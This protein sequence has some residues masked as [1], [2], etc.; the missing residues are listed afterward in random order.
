MPDPQL[1]LVAS[2]HAVKKG[3]HR[4]ELKLEDDNGFEEKTISIQHSKESV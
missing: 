3:K 1:M 4:K 2:F